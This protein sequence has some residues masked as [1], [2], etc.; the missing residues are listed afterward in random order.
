MLYVHVLVLDLNISFDLA[1]GFQSMY[2]FLDFLENSVW[3][4]GKTLRN[5]LI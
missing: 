1:L 4:F 2:V 5:V 3:F